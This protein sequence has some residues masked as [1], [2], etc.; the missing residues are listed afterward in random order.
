MAST[1]AHITELDWWET[2]TLP[3]GALSFTAAPAQHF[4]GRALFDRNRKSLWSSF[5]L[6]DGEAADFLSADTGLTDES[7]EIGRQ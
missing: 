4:S 2:H 5:V 6:V 7:T 3:G 1:R